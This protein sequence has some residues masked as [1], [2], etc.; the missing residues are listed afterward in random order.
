MDENTTEQLQLLDSL[1]AY[2]SKYDRLTKAPSDAEPGQFFLGNGQFG[3]VDAE[4][5]YAMIRHLKPKQVVEVGSGFSTALIALAVAD[6]VAEAKRNNKPLKVR[7]ESVDPVAPGF[8]YKVRGANLTVK[9]LQDTDMLSILRPGDMLIVDSSHIW[10][11]TG[12]VKAIFDALPALRGVYV[13]FH[14]IFLPYDYPEQWADRGYDEQVHLKAFL[15]ANPE[16]KVLLA[17][18]QLHRD[19]PDALADAI[20]SYDNARPIGPGSFW[21]HAPAKRPISKKRVS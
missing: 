4:L 1:K 10:T 2:R 20:G 8:S 18:N 7:F 14:D 15:E 11:E 16:W 21:I 6:T 9:R 5:M 19:E 3:S 13:H 17:A 12:E